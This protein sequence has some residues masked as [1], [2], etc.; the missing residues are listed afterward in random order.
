M[1]IL[2]NVVICVWPRVQCLSSYCGYNNAFLILW[3]S[4]QYV[5]QHFNIYNELQ[6]CFTPSRRPRPQPTLEWR[7]QCEAMTLP[8][9]AP[10]Q[11][12]YRIS[13]SR[14]FQFPNLTV[15]NINYS[16]VHNNP[17]VQVLTTFRNTLTAVEYRMLLTGG[18]R[19]KKPPFG[20]RYGTRVEH[21]NVFVKVV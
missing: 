5:Y 13:T 19:L 1:S 10:L 6:T 8:K 18:R 20:F 4:H 11:V 15:Q 21:E 16:I 17:S 12:T 2:C 7:M 3:I 9:A 14:Y